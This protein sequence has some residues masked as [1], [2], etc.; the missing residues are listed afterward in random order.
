MKRIGKITAVLLVS[1]I[2]MT[3]G[4]CSSPNS[5]KKTPAA[6]QTNKV[7]ASK[8]SIAFANLDTCFYSLRPRED[9]RYPACEYRASIT[10]TETAVSPDGGTMVRYKSRFDYAL[11]DDKQVSILVTP[12]QLEIGGQTIVYNETLSAAREGQYWIEDFPDIGIIDLDASDQ[13]KEIVLS[14]PIANNYYQQIVYRFDGS[15][16]IELADVSGTKANYIDHHGKIVKGGNYLDITDPM[17]ALSYFQC[18]GN[19]L[20][21][22]T[23]DQS[24]LLGKKYIY[25]S[26][27]LQGD[28]TVNFYETP[29]APHLNYPDIGNTE[30]LSPD[31]E[32]VTTLG[33]R[34]GAKNSTYRFAQGETFTLLEMSRERVRNYG[35]WY[36]VQLEDGKRGVIYWWLAG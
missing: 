24:K 5:A 22:T 13:Y 26:A 35:A 21:E 28:R 9:G 32:Y 20:K 33:E 10:Q 19:N 16:I 8:D 36:Y 2:A 23:V 4:A 6:T 17:V 27:G 11:C 1:A 14:T 25:G 3:L 29:T 12:E 7:E 30:G 15:H 31:A 34:K 18:E